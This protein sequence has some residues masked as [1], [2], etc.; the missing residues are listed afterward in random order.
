MVAHARA[1]RAAAL[2]LVLGAVTLVM[3]ATRWA[4]PGPAND[5]GLRGEAPTPGLQDAE[6]AVG[7]SEASPERHVVA[8]SAD[9]VGGDA[10]A[11]PPPE[12]PARIFGVACLEDGHALPSL[13]L[14]AVRASTG[15]ESSAA[16]AS[17]TTDRSG[18]F[19][20]DGLEPGRY[21]FS[22][23]SIAGLG[24]SLGSHATGE[25]PVDVVFRGYLLRVVLLDE[26]EGTLFDA[27][28]VAT[29]EH[30]GDEA[31][32]VTTSV[33]STDATGTVVVGLS[34]EGVV[35]L[36]T[37]RPDGRRA[38][39]V[40]EVRGQGRLVD[41]ELVVPARS[42][43]ETHA[44]LQLEVLDAAGQ[45]VSPFQVRLTPDD[46]T[47]PRQVTSEELEPTD[48]WVHDLPAGSWEVQLVERHRFPLENY[49]EC[50]P[51]R[52]ELRAGARAAVRLRPSFGGRLEISNARS[53][54]VR[55]RRDA[56]IQG[57][58]VEHADLTLVWPLSDEPDGMTVG[59]SLSPGQT[60][61]CRR[62][63]P[64]GVYTL[65]YRSPDGPIR[66][67]FDIVPGRITTV[68]F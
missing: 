44:S 20:L 19:V 42:L 59:L 27:P 11:T 43:P 53:E 23:R 57:D 25:A 14:S 8:T 34:T 2:V 51:E 52:V 33:R 66:R 28:V 21:A 67:T 47:G 26:Q 61:F 48:G 16:R 41:V 54:E 6:L 31:G 30:G 55:L 45:P 3:L 24:P 5:T 36:T 32:V 9:P 4:R 63:L 15:N 58:G 49:V 12:S 65:V 56:T 13:E 35:T 50:P 22:Q 17:T 46:G 37:E 38:R 1:R 68:T 64:P 62:V 60:A 29:L 10:A 40:C 18:R 39:A 7:A